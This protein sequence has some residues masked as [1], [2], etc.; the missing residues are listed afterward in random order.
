MLI[1]A[2]LRGA[3]PAIAACAFLVFMSGCADLSTAS[4]TTPNSDSGTV[5]GPTQKLGDGLAKT[6][7]TLGDDGHPTEVG[8]RLTAAALN[9]LPQADTTLMLAFPDQAATTAFN[10]VMLNWNHQGHEP[11]GLFD[12]PHFDFHFVM[13]D[14]ATMQSIN[15]SDPNYATKAEHFPEAKYVPQ[16]YVLPPGP[17]A[18]AQ[19]VPGMGV[20]LVDSTDTSLVPGKYDFTQILINGVWDGRYIFHEPMITRA[21]LLTEPSLDQPL[22]LPRAYQQ[23]AYY[24]TTYGVHFDRQAN[25]YVVSLG[26]LTMRDAS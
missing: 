20:H 10:H 14:M 16:D 23:S 7:V 17:P 1:P 25:E 4:K 12:K 19:A 6:Y 2:R 24:P 13:A 15:P 18:A 8:V 9:G 5:F 3:V 26:S 21:W 22:K 11:K